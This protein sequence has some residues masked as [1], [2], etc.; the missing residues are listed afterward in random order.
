MDALMMTK[1]NMNGRKYITNTLNDE[2]HKIK[3]T[4]AL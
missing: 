1:V 2:K 4:L 3:K